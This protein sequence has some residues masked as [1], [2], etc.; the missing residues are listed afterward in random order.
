MP[1]VL[2][3]STSM[4][5]EIQE[6]FQES[7]R[8]LNSRASLY[9]KQELKKKKKQFGKNIVHMFIDEGYEK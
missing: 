2:S 3:I 9:S 7:L 4:A 8:W 1:Y 6:A 5:Q